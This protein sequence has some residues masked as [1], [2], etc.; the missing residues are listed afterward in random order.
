MMPNA[1]SHEKWHSMENREIGILGQVLTF[2]GLSHITSVNCF[3]MSWDRIFYTNNYMYADYYKDTVKIIR[4][5][6]WKQQSAAERQ[7]MIGI[8]YSKWFLEM[9]R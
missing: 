2:I 7:F 4:K 9:L 1:N 5:A 6:L 3:F 8:E